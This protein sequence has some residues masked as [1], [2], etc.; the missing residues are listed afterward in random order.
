MTFEW[1]E[2]AYQDVVS[3]NTTIGVFLGGGNTKLQ[4]LWSTF[5][6]GDVSLLKHK[7]GDETWGRGKRPVINVSW[8]D[9]KE[10]AKTLAFFGENLASYLRIPSLPSAI[11]LS[12]YCAALIGAVFVVVLAS[13][14]LNY[15]TQFWEPARRAAPL[16]DRPA[17]PSLAPAAQARAAGPRA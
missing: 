11:E 12:I 6:V 15:L 8:D 1:T 16:G 7:P 3:G 17:A 2:L 14:L 5:T 10:Y 4:P 13:F 9:A